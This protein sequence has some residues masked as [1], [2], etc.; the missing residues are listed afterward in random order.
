MIITAH[1]TSESR[2]A[3]V[4][5]K[6]RE[7]RAEPSRMVVASHGSPAAGRLEGVVDGYWI[8]WNDDYI[9][10]SEIADGHD[11]LQDTAPS[12]ARPRGTRTRSVLTP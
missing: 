3:L 7:A 4:A 8:L 5:R 1:H 11:Q 2:K 12:H 10:R 9:V 6:T